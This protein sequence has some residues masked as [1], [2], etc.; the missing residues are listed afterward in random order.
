MLT[1]PPNIKPM[2]P[3]IRRLLLSLSAALASLPAAAQR[4]E[5]LHISDTA[6][7]LRLHMPDG[8]ASHPLP[9]PVYRFS[10]CDLNGDGTEE[11]LVGVVKP[12]RYYPQP[13]RRLFIF[14]NYRGQ[15]RPLW[16]GSRLGGILHDFCC[17]AD[18]T[19]VSLES[20][21]KGAYSI[22]RYRLA[23][24]GLAFDA[25]LLQGAGKQYATEKFDQY[26]ENNPDNNIAYPC[27]MPSC[28]GQ[29]QAAPAAH[30][31]QRPHRR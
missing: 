10:R 21:A 1:L 8:T 15:V 3:D 11:A 31:G 4:F 20:D 6:S 9:W 26:A 13:G 27:P 18:G 2:K 28:T 29:A 25:Y 16:L 23:K 14:K 12:T 19:V 22:C 5:L 24:F 17:C 30:P 7:V